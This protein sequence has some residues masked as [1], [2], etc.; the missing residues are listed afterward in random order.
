MPTE[1]NFN[2][3]NYNV[4]A[5]LVTLYFEDIVLQTF[6]I[7]GNYQTAKDIVL[8]RIYKLSKR[9]DI[10]E[11][12]PDNRKRLLYVSA[13]FSCLRYLRD[14]KSH[15]YHHQRALLNAGLTG[16]PDVGIKHDNDHNY[17]QI[18]GLCE[19]LP[20]KCKAVM[21]LLLLEG[22][23]AGQV[24]KKLN[25]NINAVQTHKSRGIKALM[26]LIEKHGLHTGVLP[27]VLLISLL[28]RQW[29]L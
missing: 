3:V 11:M 13:K 5:E 14:V 17:R 24:A 1:E 12:P 16:Q 27:M 28:L 23:T 10:E 25:M 29:H 7:V 21:K 8:E 26:G 20:K 22:M 18:A 2:G 15:Q 4:A 19:Q 9:P 6:D